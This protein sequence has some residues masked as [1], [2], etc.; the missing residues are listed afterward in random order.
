[1]VSVTLPYN[2]PIT[3]I[4]SFLLRNS[5]FFFL[6]RLLTSLGVGLRLKDLEGLVRVILSAKPFKVPWKKI[7]GIFLIAAGLPVPMNAE[8]PF[9]WLLHEEAGEKVGLTCFFTGQLPHS[10]DPRCTY[11]HYH[12]L[13]LSSPFCSVHNTLNTCYPSSMKSKFHATS[14]RW[15]AAPLTPMYKYLLNSVT[16]ENWE[17]SK[18]KLSDPVT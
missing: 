18:R 16:P 3:H 4:P 8:K 7:P 15:L 12:T 1:M 2:F 9:K 11:N 5:R 13:A 14:S 17:K 10:K 6:G